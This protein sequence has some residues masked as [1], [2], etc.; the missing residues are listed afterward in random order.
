M[1][2]HPSR[3]RISNPLMLRRRHST[4]G[5]AFGR[6]VV[7]R[8]A[9][10]L[11]LLCN[12]SPAL[13][14]D[15][16]DAEGTASE[17]PALQQ[18]EFVMYTDPRFKSYQR[19]LIVS[20]E[21]IPLWLEA[22]SRPDP[23]LQR[24]T[25]DTIAIAHER[26][27]VGIESTLP[28]LVEL[29][30]KKDLDSEVAFAVAR[31]L[32]EFDARDQAPL[33][34]ELANQHGVMLAAVVERALVDWKSP[35]LRQNWSERL[36]ASGVRR[37]SL[38]LAIEGLGALGQEDESERLLEL[39]RDRSQAIS[40]R[41]AAARSLGQI[42]ASGLTDQAV[43]LIG[44]PEP[45][46]LADFLAIALLDRH[47]DAKTIEILLS[48]T[49]S[50]NTAVQSE[51]LSRL[52]E[53]DYKIVLQ[54]APR[55]LANRDVNVRRIVAE[56]MI[57]EQDKRWIGD[58]ASLLDD[59]NPGLRRHV[60]AELFRL[61]QDADLQDEIISQVSGILDQDSWR[62]CEQA[63]L[64]LISLDHKPAGDRLV[65]LMSHPRGEVKAT[66]GWGL[67]RLGQPKHLPAMLG[68]ARE[69]YDGFQNGQLNQDTPGVVDLISQLFLA[70]GQMEYHE[71]DELI[72]KYIPRNISL[73]E[74]ARSAA[75]WAIGRL[76]KGNADQELVDALVERVKDVALPQPEFDTVRRMSAISLGRMNA[77]S[78]VP[79]LRDFTSYP[80]GLMSQSCYWAIERIT[81]ETPPTVDPPPPVDYGDWFL[82]PVGDN[83]EE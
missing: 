65:D 5:S 39:A 57:D 40:I 60:A 67:R 66:A 75:V 22:L 15:D 23:M 62:G 82:K 24:V 21:P 34:V 26:Q 16:A 68:K 37:Q 54:V 44:R 14:G 31:A 20:G 27:M 18:V 50:G 3:L 53:I 25:V 83:D 8:I 28:N 72:R 55:L 30:G 13:L 1:A 43:A 74:R 19:E 58:L 52:Y 59:V 41:F 9:M 17:S 35:L 36:H 29:A 48:L 47:D 78:A 12:A 49:E 79:T 56:A 11:A 80:A 7:V 61:S 6:F 38:V 81:G 76:Y 45:G 51:A 69:V 77:E 71:A 64:I 63:T 73:S 46:N 33:L 4:I 70:F 42:H 2:S 32:V 10:V